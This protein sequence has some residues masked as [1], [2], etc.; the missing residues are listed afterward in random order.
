M[1]DKVSLRMIFRNFGFYYSETR[2][3]ESTPARGLPI[4]LARVTAEITSGFPP[5]AITLLEKNE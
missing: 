5:F 3:K 1:G 2:A 4:L